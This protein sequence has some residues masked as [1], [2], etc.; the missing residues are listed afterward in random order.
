MNKK[1][2]ILGKGGGSVEGAVRYDEPQQLTDEQKKQAQENLGI[3]LSANLKREIVDTLPS[4]GEQNIIYMVAKQATATGNV[5]DEYMYINGQWELI[6]STEVDLSGYYTKEE[7]DD[8]FL[9]EHQQIKT[10]NGESIIGEGDLEIKGFSGDYNDLINKPTILNHWF[11]TKEEYEAIVEKDENTI[12]HIEGGDS[13]WFG[14]QAQYDAL[15]EKEKDVL[16]FIEGNGGDYYTK[17]ETDT[18]IQGVKE[19]LQGEIDA[20][21]DNSTY[22][23]KIGEIEGVLGEKTTMAEV[24]A[25]GYLTEHQPLKT[26]NGEEIV[27]EGDIEIKGG[28]ELEVFDL[29]VRSTEEVIALK[30]DI[31]AGKAISYDL[32]YNSQQLTLKAKGTS[33]TDT[34]F[35]RYLNTNNFSSLNVIN[36]EIRI[37]KNGRVYDF[38]PALFTLFKNTITV[39][40]GDE[41]K[42]SFM[43]LNPDS[44]ANKTIQLSTVPSKLS[45][46]END[47]GFLT[48]HQS[49]DNYYTKSETDNKIPTKT[50]ELVFELADGTTKTINVFVK[51]G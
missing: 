27:G 32:R 35:H 18:A 23:A 41:T 37:D 7:A 25:K 29:A 30:N 10:I 33:T 44:S 1:I 47:S 6:G 5:Y 31:I 4:E 16:Y 19:T 46:L 51:E 21:V 36:Q 28:E 26:I 24:E 15:T 39:K 13:M 14:T 9:T 12:Y 2:I 48:E 50:S 45:E 22:E 40:Q 3:D 8:K 34:V 42:G 20:K 49:L 11:G 38:S 43:S 17:E